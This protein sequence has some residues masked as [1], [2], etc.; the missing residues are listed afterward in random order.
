MVL[1]DLIRSFQSH[2]GLRYVAVSI[3]FCDL[4]NTIKSLNI[5]NWTQPKFQVYSLPVS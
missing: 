2:I 4:Q 1:E 5:I 3:N